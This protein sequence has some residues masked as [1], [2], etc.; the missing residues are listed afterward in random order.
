VKT[1]KF[2]WGAWQENRLKEGRA[3][4]EEEANTIVKMFQECPWCRIRDILIDAGITDERFPQ[5]YYDVW[6]GTMQ[7]FKL[8]G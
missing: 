5:F 2:D 7:T 8:R 3:P 6:T 4:T 1:K